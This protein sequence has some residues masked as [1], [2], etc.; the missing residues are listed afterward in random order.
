M[1]ITLTPIITLSSGICNSLEPY[2]SSP[3]ILNGA[4]QS[5]LLGW[6]ASGGETL[7]RKWTT[8]RARP[9][10]CSDCFNLEV[11]MT[12][13]HCDVADCLPCSHAS[14]ELTTPDSKQH[15]SYLKT[16]SVHCMILASFSFCL[17]YHKATAFSMGTRFY[18]TSSRLAHFSF[19]CL[20]N[21]INAWDLHFP[22]YPELWL[23]SEAMYPLLLA[24]LTLPKNTRSRSGRLQ[25]IQGGWH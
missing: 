6:K 20:Y 23:N 4:L 1:A 12:A 22:H 21:Y 18:W 11:S 10:D 8:Y 19:A 16:I 15:R 25:F 7:R 5:H 24:R 3:H 17:P 9:Y 14:G 2:F 13:L